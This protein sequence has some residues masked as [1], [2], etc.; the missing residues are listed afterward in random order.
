MVKM[1]VDHAG[2]EEIAVVI[3]LVDHH[4]KRLPAPETCF[5]KVFW[6]QLLFEKGISRA[7]VHQQAVIPE[8]TIL[9][10]RHSIPLTP[11]ELFIRSCTEQEAECFPSP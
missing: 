9:Q 8:L 1:A 6:S 7:D 4:L 3:A 10:Q 5:A 11:F 2:H